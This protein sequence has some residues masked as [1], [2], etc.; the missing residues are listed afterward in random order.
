MCA[1]L[2]QEQKGESF[3]TSSNWNIHRVL[4][5]LWVEG[6]PTLCLFSWQDTRCFDIWGPAS[7]TRS[8]S[9]PSGKVQ[10]QAFCS[11]GKRGREAQVLKRGN[12]ILTAFISRFHRRPPL[13]PCPP[14]RPPPPTTHT[15]HCPPSAVPA[16]ALLNQASGSSPAVFLRVKSLP[17]RILRC[18]GVVKNFLKDRWYSFLGHFSEMTKDSFMCLHIIQSVYDP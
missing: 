11:P 17:L 3:F 12:N 9:K 1:K 7:Y 4:Y 15:S 5:N 2:E 14:P 16:G 18:T 10:I 6:N 13:W 8:K